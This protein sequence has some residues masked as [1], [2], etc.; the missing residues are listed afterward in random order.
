MWLPTQ[1]QVNAATRHI[2]S[3]IGGGI[4]VFGLSTK[5]D[6]ATVTNIIGA[7]GTVIN[8]VI[9]LIGLVSPLIA[10]YYASKSASPAS[11]AASI[12]K[13]EPGTIVVTTPEIAKAT[14]DAP[15]VVSKDDVRVVN[16]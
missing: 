12:T 11:Q 14:P 10:G 5:I 16:K 1:A 15:N 4:L 6:P 2:A 9:V 7:A 13:T 3:A 8:D